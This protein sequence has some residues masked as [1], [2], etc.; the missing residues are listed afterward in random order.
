MSCDVRL[1]FIFEEVI[2][3]FDCT[4]LEGYR[5]NEKQ[6]EVYDMGLSHTKPGKSKHNKKPSL[7]IDVAPYPVDWN[8][9]YRFYYFAGVVKGIALQLD[10]PL[11]W[12]GDWDGDTDLHDQSFMDLV[13][14]ELS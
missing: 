10:I 4:I 1:H 9:I 3:H 6:Q 2:K 8:D 7:A 12:G 11:R 13:H 14:F 5:S